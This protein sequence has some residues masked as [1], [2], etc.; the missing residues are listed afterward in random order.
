[1]SENIRVDMSNSEFLGKFLTKV[2]IFRQKEQYLKNYIY[3]RRNIFIK[4]IIS[5]R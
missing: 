3:F 1:M 2:I 4:C 5:V